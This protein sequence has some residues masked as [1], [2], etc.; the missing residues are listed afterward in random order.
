[1]STPTS[2]GSTSSGEGEGWKLVTCERKDLDQIK[3]LQLQNTFITLKAEVEVNTLISKVSGPSNPC[4]STKK[5]HDVTVMG[6]SLL[7]Q[8]KAPLC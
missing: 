1:M 6:D 3:A 5:K 8:T 7:W 4:R 2:K